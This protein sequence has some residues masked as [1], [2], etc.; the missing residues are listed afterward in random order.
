MS[1]KSLEPTHLK[2]IVKFDILGELGNYLY[3]VL[4][5]FKN[6]LAGKVSNASE[7]SRKNKKPI[8]VPKFSEF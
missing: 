5:E 4:G 3:N 2:F 1:S 7:D 6:F 8:S